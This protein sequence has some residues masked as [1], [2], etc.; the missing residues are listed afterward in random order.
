MKRRIGVDLGLKSTHKVVVVEESGIASRPTSIDVSLE[1]FL[2]LR[3]L[4]FN[5]SDR[6]AT[7][8]VMEP[9]GNVWLPLAAF[10]MAEGVPVVISNPR[11]VSDFRK[12]LRRYVKTD[13]VDADAMARLT[14]VDPKRSHV[15][16]MPSVDV[17]SLRRVVKER[18]RFVRDAT[19]RKLRIGSAM[20]LANPRLMGCFGEE[21]FSTTA[22]VMFR[23]FVDPFS[24]VRLGEKRFTQRLRQ[25]GGRAPAEQVH[26]ILAACEKTCALYSEMLRRKALPFNYEL[27]AREIGMELAAME[28]A[29]AQV[30]VLDESIKELYGRV[31]PAQTLRLIPGMGDIIAAA[32]EAFSSPIDRFHNAKAYASYCGLVPRMSQTGTAPHD[33]SHHIT[34]CGNRLLKKYFHLAAEISRQQDPDLAAYY[35]AKS[36]AGW[37]HGR[38]ITA[39]AHKL[40]RRVY[41]LLQRRENDALRPNGDRQPQ[42]YNLRVPDGNIVDREAAKA[43]VKEHYPS[44]REQARRAAERAKSK[45]DASQLGN[46]GQPKG[47]TNRVKRDHVPHATVHHEHPV[48]QPANTIATAVQN[49]VE[50]A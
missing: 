40:V 41:A 12:V 4:A 18:D 34:K 33:H 1:G 10:L 45:R 20:Q 31:D 46:K 11:K 48:I 3:D 14:Q 43:Y 26:E 25:K 44:K 50:N 6:C 42:V 21:K 24:V 13:V 8:V 7:H 32:I 2:K 19:A 37:H 38:I 17:L 23:D 27:M 39:I 47:S 49:P 28:F 5:G 9:T 30:K 36:A 29:E 35:A 15:F 22:R 16:E